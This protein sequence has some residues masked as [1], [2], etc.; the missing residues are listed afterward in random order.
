MKENY[1]S[2]NVQLFDLLFS[3]SGILDSNVFL[4]SLF[5]NIKDYL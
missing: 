2:N 1:E 4:T 5:F 3:I